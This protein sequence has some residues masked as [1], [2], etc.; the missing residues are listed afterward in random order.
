MILAR[1]LGHRLE[2]LDSEALEITKYKGPFPYMNYLDEVGAYYTERIAVQ[3]T[4]VR[5]L[6]FSIVM[7]SQ[8]QE[9]I[10]SQTSATNVATLMQNAGTKVAGKIVSDDKTAKTITNAAG[11]EARANMVSLQR[12]DGIIGTSWIDGDHINIQMEN[13]INVQDLI[14]LQPG[15]NYT[16]FQGDP[17]PGASF[18]IEPQDKTCNAPVIINRYITINPPNL[19]QLRKLV[20][21]TAQ[22]RLPAP[23]NVSKIIGVLTEKP[24]RRGKAAKAEPWKIIDTFQ[25]RLANRQEAHNLMTEYDTDHHGREEN[26][27]EEALEVIRTTTMAERTIRYITL[28]KPESEPTQVSAEEIQLAP[29]AILRTL[30][31]PQPA[32]IPPSRYRNEPFI[33][34][35][36]PDSPHP[37]M[38]WPE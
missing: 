9:R 23:E 14:K 18:Y 4:Q 30:T 27:W 26:L 36:L 38:E 15:E 3:A 31:L 13:K 8:D 1:D 12:R 33:S 35:K 2:G 24:S 5:S 25:Q 21:R 10:E 20:P 34:P 17:V 29:D 11:Q 16:V 28:N 6:D 37:D 32:Y 19:K 22:R 7:M